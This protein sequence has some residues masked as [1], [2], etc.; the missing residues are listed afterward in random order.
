M[1][2]PSTVAAGFIID[3]NNPLDLHYWSVI[4]KTDPRQL[5]K[6]VK[7]VSARVT[8]IKDFIASGVPVEEAAMDNPTLEIY[9]HYTG[10]IYRFACTITLCE[11]NADEL[12]IW[13]FRMFI[14][15]NVRINNKKELS[16]MLHQLIIRVITESP[17]EGVRKLLKEK[18]HTAATVS[19]VLFENITIA[20]P[21][22]E[23]LLPPDKITTA[24]YNEIISSGN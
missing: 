24:I 15:L 19:Q 1:E 9:N 20:D 12:L 2:N 5:K 3:V 6:L 18:F 8:D 22:A 11:K 21:C 4:L 13:L 23:F 10:M 17:F 7:T 16:L 14:Q